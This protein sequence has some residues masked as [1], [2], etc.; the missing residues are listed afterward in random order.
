MGIGGSGHV[1]RWQHWSLWDELDYRGS[2]KEA[3]CLSEAY[4]ILKFQLWV[5]KNPPSGILT[6]GFPGSAPR[7]SS[8][9][10]SYL[11]S[12]WQD[13]ASGSLGSSTSSAL[14]TQPWAT[15]LYLS[16][17]IC[18]MGLR[19]QL[20]IT[21]WVNLGNTCRAYGPEQALRKCYP[22]VFWCRGS[23]NHLS[24]NFSKEWPRAFLWS[25]TWEHL[26]G[27]FRG[28]GLHH[29]GVCWR[30]FQVME[31]LSVEPI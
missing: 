28:T 23:E 22:L 3:T 2:P 8:L 17:F 5:H 26:H 16:F 30:G 27:N 15:T 24:R 12:T 18:E 1:Q 31:A 20:C 21:V 13:L 9:M 6:C 14:M 7:I 25:P 4:A 11:I 10:L 19:E 29:G